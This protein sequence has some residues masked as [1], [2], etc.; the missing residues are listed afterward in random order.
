MHCFWKLAPALALLALA[1][2]PTLAQTGH[3]YD[4]NGSYAD[5]S[6]GPSLTGDGGTLG[7]TGYTFGPNQGL[8]VLNAVS[9]SVYH[10]DLTFQFTDVGGYRKL[11]D[12]S[13][14]NSDNGLYIY[15][16][17]LN[18]YPTITGAAPV[19]VNQLTN[20]VLDRDAAGTVTGFVNG[21]QQFSFA[22]TSNLGV[23]NAPGNVIHFFEDDNAT[24]QREASGGFVDRITIDSPNVAPVP[25]ASTAVST[26]LLLM[27]GVAG[28]G[29]A[30]RRKTVAAR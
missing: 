11:I 23:F 3:V 26:G 22:D 18:F 8:T 4:L 28:F 21:V 13:D 14:K 29:V 27:L 17:N 5:A 7:A 16:G 10:I 12:F 15:N 6:G 9:S 24:G 30:R 20:V 2:S 19:A 1:A 25:E